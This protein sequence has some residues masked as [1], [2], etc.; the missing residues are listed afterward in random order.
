MQGF[1]FGQL[2]REQVEYS[3]AHLDEVQTFFD[4]F[5]LYGVEFQW[6]CLNQRVLRLQI[7][8]HCFDL[9]NVLLENRLRIL[10][11][12]VIVVDQVLSHEQFGLVVL[13]E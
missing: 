8:D 5:Q 7:H 10:L 9:L 13:S 2:A 4:G 11:D 6:L 1:E 3:F 12:D